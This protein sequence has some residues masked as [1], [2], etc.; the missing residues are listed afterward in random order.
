MIFESERV[1][2]KDTFTRV[3]NLIIVI[4][5]IIA[6]YYLINYLSSVLLP[7]LVAAILA[8]FV[9]PMVTL[10]RRFLHIHNNTLAVML[11]LIEVTGVVTLIVMS[12]IPYL[13]MEVS[14][15]AKLVTAYAKTKTEEAILPEE[16]QR[17]IVSYINSNDFERLVT[18]DGVVSAVEN[19]LY[20][21]WSLMGTSFKLLMSL[22]SWVIML[23]YFVF[24]LLD[25]DRIENFF[26]RAIPKRHKSWVRRVVKDINSAM[27]QYFRAQVIIASLVGVLFAIGF[28]IIGLPMA[29][30]LGIF[31]GV[32]N[33][34]PY[35]QLL[36]IPIAA[37]LGIVLCVTTGQSVVVLAVEITLV[38]LIVQGIQDL[39]LTPRI[40]GKSMG[41]S[42]W[43]ILLSLAVWGALLGFIGLIIALPLTTLLLSY[44]KEFVL[45][46]DAEETQSATAEASKPAEETASQNT[47]TKE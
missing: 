28:Y 24:L 2:K 47:E 46:E 16:V 12:V 41:L 18:S 43:L 38:Y 33:L 22:F 31:V 8:Y 42:P 37:L 39:V 5:I 35:L 26:R 29:I 3:V 30:G 34:V 45:K 20:E 19:T 7:F 15:M 10:N 40:M 25:Y 17:Y 6:C 4:A 21:V 27:S 23:L 14:Q 11:T 32:L 13:E 44:F 1:E 36:S 9:R